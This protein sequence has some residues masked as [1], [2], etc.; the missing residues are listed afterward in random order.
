[1]ATECWPLWIH[2]IGTLIVGHFLYATPTPTPIYS[3]GLV[4]LAERIFPVGCN[5]SHNLSVA[6]RGFATKRWT[7]IPTNYN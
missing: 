5:I 1:M 2:D 4:A 6:H 7:N 3:S